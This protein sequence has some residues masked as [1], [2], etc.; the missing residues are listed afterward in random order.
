MSTDRRVALRRAY[1]NLGWGELAATATFAIVA[2]GMV[3]SRLNSPAQVWALWCALIPLLVVLLQAGVYWLLAR[4]WV[5]R[6]RMP[7]PIAALY[8]SF[9]LLDPVLLVA[10]LC[11]IVVWWPDEPWLAIVLLAIW[12]F[13][14]VEYLNYFVVRLSYPVARWFVL[15]GQ[16]RTPRLVQDLQAAAER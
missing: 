7:R 6:A 10:G 4:G 9:R 11:G 15:V 3:S 1:L 13:G 2:A 14:V 16:W 8:R 5:E 12:A